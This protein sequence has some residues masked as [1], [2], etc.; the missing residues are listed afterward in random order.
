MNTIQKINSNLELISKHF[1]N[2]LRSIFGDKG[3]ILI[4]IGAVFIYPI[5]YSLGYMNESLT[6]ISVGIVD[7][8]RSAASMKYAAMIDATAELDVDCKPTDIIEAEK[9]FM[10]NSIEGVIL[11]PKGFE[12]DLLSEQQTN[13]AI[14]A[15]AGYFLKYKNTYMAVSYVNAYFGGAIGVKHYLAEGQS[16]QKAT[17]SINPLNIQ[18]QILYNPAS[19]YGSFIMPGLIIIVLQQTLLIGIGLMGGS[20]SESKASPFL[21][22]F[23][24]RRKEIIPY[25]LGKSGAYI[26]ISAFNVSFAV[27]LVHDWFSYPDKSNILD[28][29]IL[30]LPYLLSVIFLGIGLST[31][32]K[33]R[34]SAIVFMVFLSPI[35]LFVNGLSWPTSAMPDWIVNLS[36]TLPSTTVVPA[37]LRLRTMGASLADIRSEL[38]TLYCQAGIYFLL[39]FSYFYLRIFINYRK[40]IGKLNEHKK[41]TNC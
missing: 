1:R 38:T 26:L 19:G 23:R 11:I 36:K 41:V 9:L 34:E 14:Y 15:D 28:V 20:F 22:S 31:L 35:A 32:F 24:K 10:Q 18:T 4:L 13:V 8:D 33:H 27:I 37:Y 39:T 17:A 16:L 7:Q 25:L 29:I 5:I 3:A 6:D 2:E 21:L 40:R 12:R 30:L